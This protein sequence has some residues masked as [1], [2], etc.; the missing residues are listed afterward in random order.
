MLRVRHPLAIARRKRAT[1][2]LEGAEKRIAIT[3]PK[4]ALVTITRSFSIRY[5]ED[6]PCMKLLTAIVAMARDLDPS[7]VLGDG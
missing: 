7:P 4:K 1:E 6:I 3:Q 5:N 2:A